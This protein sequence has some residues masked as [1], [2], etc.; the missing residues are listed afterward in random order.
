M[1]PMRRN[2]LVI[3]VLVV[4]VMGAY[5][6]AT[7]SSEIGLNFQVSARLAPMYNLWFHRYMSTTGSSDCSWI[8]ARGQ[9]VFAQTQQDVTCFHQAN[10]KII[11]VTYLDRGVYLTDPLAQA[12]WTTE[13]AWLH[14]QNGSR[15]SF[16]FN[17]KALYFPNPSDSNVRTWESSNWVTQWK[18]MGVDGLFLDDGYNPCLINSRYRVCTPN[19]LPLAE[20][21]SGDYQLWVQAWS[22][23]AN[24]IKP[25]IGKPFHIYPNGVDWYSAA[26]S[27]ILKAW[28]S[29]MDGDFLEYYPR[30]NTYGDEI[31][32]YYQMQN[33][34]YTTNPKAIIDF[35]PYCSASN[36]PSQYW[37]ASYY[38]LAKNF[39]TNNLYLSPPFNYP[40][41]AGVACEGWNT[42]VWDRLNLGSPKGA[43][44][45]IDAFGDGTD[46]LYI[47]LFQN[48]IVIAM[49]HRAAT[50]TRTIT[51][52]LPGA[53]ENVTG[54]STVT[55]ITIG[56]NN[57]F[58]GVI[59]GTQLVA[60]AA[61]VF[62]PFLALAAAVFPGMLIRRLR[63]NKKTY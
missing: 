48:G 26:N 13:S 17:G 30:P 58:I 55:N 50:D 44:S 6:G 36:I 27:T 45:I 23:W 60:A 51:V 39:T 24:W 25:Q 3:A 56:T 5:A 20:F 28:L 63:I 4:I 9:I 29:G 19:G 59:P 61:P 47:R 43:A 35:F 8:G 57:A 11:T 15:A 52:N 21:N 22:D 33:E 2:A 34:Y 49:Q 10:P 1:T 18:T 62:P 40:V 14:W 42:A 37:L 54:G 31:S 12:L 38:L 16:T 7:L 46:S 41:P 32:W 53:Y